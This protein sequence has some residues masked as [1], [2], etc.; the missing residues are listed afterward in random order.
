MKLHKYLNIILYLIVP[1]LTLTGYI[2]INYIVN[3]SFNVK[4]NALT[5]ALPETFVTYSTIIPPATTP[6]SL[7]STVKPESSSSEPYIFLTSW[8][9]RKFNNIKD[10][11]GFKIALDTKGY[12]FVNE[13]VVISN[14]D[15][16][17]T[18]RRYNIQK[19]SSNGEFIQ[20]FDFQLGDRKG[21]LR[22]P[23]DFI[24][25]R[26]RYIYIVDL[27]GNVKKFDWNGYFIGEIGSSGS[28]DGQFKCPAGICLDKENYIY[29]VDPGQRERFIQKF[30]SNGGF[31]EKWYCG[32]LPYKSV[33]PSAIE[34]NSSG[35]FY[36]VDAVEY[37]LPE[38]ESD[39]RGI[40]YYYRL[41]KMEQSGKWLKNRILD[42]NQSKIPIPEA[43]FQ[44]GNEYF[45]KCPDITIDSK[46]NILATDYDEN[47]ILIYDKNLKFITRFGESGSGPGQ[48]KYPEGIVADSEGNLYVVDSGNYR[49]QKFKLNPEF[50]SK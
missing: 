34:I 31:I 8:N 46:G 48:F 4:D 32:S 2:I 11:L 36:F 38:D 7:I 14:D 33:M 47:N 42:P 49:I 26:N 45:Y 23:V 35:S 15:Y 9:F 20:K 22:H 17:I 44:K 5:P 37:L 16:D 10:F 29:V 40:F 39:I 13:Y 12:V 21:Q 1:V 28:K 27:S 25:D 19:F 24:I 41:N 43:E 18:D 30:D 3:H 50:K 6:I